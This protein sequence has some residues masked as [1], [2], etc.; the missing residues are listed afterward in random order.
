MVSSKTSGCGWWLHRRVKGSRFRRFWK[1]VRIGSETSG[2]WGW[3]KSCYR[4]W[5]RLVEG[6]MGSKI[7]GCREW[8][9]IRYRWKWIEGRCWRWSR[10]LAEACGIEEVNRLRWYGRNFRF[11]FEDAQRMTFAEESRFAEVRVG[12]RRWRKDVLGGLGPTVEDSFG[13]RLRFDWCRK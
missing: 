11:W 12:S 13:F 1:A 2:Y 4:R 5:R 9:K 8:R 3:R 6:R 7:C 10:W